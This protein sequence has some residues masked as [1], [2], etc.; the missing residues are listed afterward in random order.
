[1]QLGGA[2]MNTISSLVDFIRRAEQNLQK[3]GMNA[4][5]FR[6]QPDANLPCIPSI[7]RPPY[8]PEDI[9]DGKRRAR[10]TEFSVY[11]R[12]RDMS[13]SLEPPSIAGAGDKFEAGWRR[14]VLA[15]HQG[16]PTRLL[17]WSTKPLVALFFAVHGSNQHCKDVPC[18]LCYEKKKS[19]D[20]DAGVFM[21]KYPKR[22]LFS[23][24]GLARRH[25]HP[26]AYE[27][28]KNQEDPG[29]FVPPDIYLRVAVQGSVFSIA[30]KPWKPVE[31]KPW[32]IVPAQ[33][34]GE[35]LDEL[36]DMGISYATLFPDLEGIAKWLAEKSEREAKRKKIGYRRLY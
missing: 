13:A 26:P 20:H 8:R 1:M 25:Q 16:V 21:T 27:K 32:V 30:S 2:T 17:D 11:T 4:L 36:E 10:S 3:A 14:L 6:G 28:R 29:F 22:R 18:K 7:G 34:R 5:L 9:F 24:D 19:R 12:F 35:I 31:K 23:I 15:R 33:L